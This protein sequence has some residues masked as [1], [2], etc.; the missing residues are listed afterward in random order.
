MVDAY[1]LAWPPGWPRTDWPQRHPAMDNRFGRARDGVL[2]EIDM[3]GGKD[4]VISS[5]IELRQDGL[6]YSNRR[7]PDDRGVAVYFKLDDEDQ[8]IPCDKWDTTGQNLRAVEMT[9]NALRGIERWGAKEMVNAAF[10]GFRALPPPSGEPIIT[11]PPWSQVL[12]L[13]EAGGIITRDRVVSAYRYLAKKHH[14]DQGGD[15]GYFMRL[16]RAYEQGVEATK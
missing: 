8:C 7:Q 12:G 15:H 5:N 3:L 2:R 13:D 9:I 1:P 6:P 10:R 4:V 16:K 14:P 11:E